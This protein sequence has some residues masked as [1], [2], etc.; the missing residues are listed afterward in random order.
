MTAEADRFALRLHRVSKAFGGVQALKAVDFE[1]RAGEV[2]CLAGE[3]GC[4]KS[5]LIKVVTGVH[6]PESA[7][8]IE[9]FGERVSK[10]NP[11]QARARGVSVIWQDLALFPYMSVAENI[12]FD[13]LV[14]LTPRPVKYRDMAA[15]AGAVLDRL[16][17]TLDLRSPL[18]ALP[19]AQRQVVAIARA[20]MN[21]ARLIF[22]DEPTASLTQAE[23]D[24]LLDIVRKLSA[25]GV[26][27]VFVSHRLAEV[28]EIAERVTVV[29][30]GNLVGVYPTEG[31]TQ[32]RLGELMTGHLIDDTVSARDVSPDAAEVFACEGLT[33]RGDFR[34]VSLKVR[35]GE[36]L[37]LTGLIGAGRTEL[38]HVMMGMTGAD[39]GE[40]MLEGRPYNPRSIREAIARG[41]AYVSE[42]R[43]SLG[44]LQK[45]SIADNT[46]ISVLKR[47]TTATGLISDRRKAELVRHWIKELGVKIGA[48]EDAI[49]T[50]SGGNQQKVV[51]AKWLATEPRLLILD[52]PT[53]GVDVGARAG[54]FRIVR[55]LADEGLAILLISDEVTE[56][57]QNADRILH[58]ADGRIVS[59]VDPRRITV[60]ELEERI[61]A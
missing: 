21:D 57:M 20:L 53:V 12:A 46:V 37:G 25:D 40:M 42:D 15:R 10:I 7:D 6:T 45:Q 29:R 27:V 54:I 44:L 18:G 39:A 28:L 38:A 49:S 16:G 30:D 36:V 31:M 32:A 34:D 23:T 41:M 52:S 61:Y 51:L 50:L 9:L 26:A 35:A 17:V 48:P 8:L 59:E 5:T 4:G 14:G 24:R 13:D 1:V 60:P 43:L 58:M 56:V 55:A 47:L 11:V 19:I 33:R 2:H 3:N 22:M